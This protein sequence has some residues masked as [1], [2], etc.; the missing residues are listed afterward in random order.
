MNY[1][2]Q[3]AQHAAL[4]V[5]TTLLTGALFYVLR[6]VLYKN[7]SQDEYGLFYVVFSCVM[8]VQT[9]V[10]FGFDPGL[11]PFITRYREEGDPS[12]IKSIALGSLVP[13]GFITAF[14]V[15]AFL[16]VPPLAAPWVAAFPDAPAL[17]R[18]LA[19][20]ASASLFR[21]LALHAVLV[22]MFKCA[23]QVL[24]GLQ[25]IAWRNA[26]DLARAI[27]CL[28]SAVALL[29]AGWG[30][31][32]TA[33]AYTLG[34]LAEA[35][36]LAIALWVSFPHIVRAR[37][38]WRPEAVRHVFDSG[39]WLSAGF[40]GI[41]VFSSVDTMIISLVRKELLDAAAY[42]IA[43]PTITIMYSLMIAA[44]ISLLPMVRTLWL[45][46]EYALLT[47]GVQRI[48]DTAIG[49]ML[50]AGVLIASGSDVLM[51]T[52]FGKNVLN[53]GD[54]FDVLAV[55]GIAFFLSYINL[56]V[57]AGIDQARAAGVAVICGLVFDVA[58]SVPLTYAFGI[59]GAAIAGV[60]GYAC[61]MGTSLVV[62]RRALAIR[63]SIKAIMVSVLISAG[64]GLAAHVLRR[65]GLI[66]LDHPVTSAVSGALLLALALA[67]LEFIGIIHL[68]HLITTIKGGQVQ[69]IREHNPKCD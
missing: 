30:I 47:E 59:R 40:G 43:L 44:G 16:A 19:H 6:I 17:F 41:V 4:T 22:L 42:Q 58:L 31:R 20:P 3:F 49:V 28:G 10:T 56:H 39:K 53:A 24:L 65:Y 37:F 29:H 2:R 54:A 62:I 69:T 15:A 8:I 1:A 57:L 45:R 55:G 32:A 67:A 36:V 9:I 52:L 64:C 68:R 21:I 12:A 61:V 5:L 63:V 35:A 23:Q 13:Q 51:T 33:A 34:A 18:T 50:P 14:V 25:A 46:K 60:L 11:V 38:T 66:H 48:Y 7:L 26:A 27:L